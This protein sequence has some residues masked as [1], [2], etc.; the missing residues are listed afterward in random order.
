MAGRI[1]IADGVAT[2]RIILKVKLATACYEVIQAD[3]AG[4]ALALARSK[5]P[6]LILLDRALPGDG[7]VACR[8]L[9]ADPMTAAI[10]LVFLSAAQDRAVR[11]AALRS[12]ADEVVAKPMHEKT[13][14]AL[15]R[16]LIRSRATRDEL[17]RRSATAG[18]LG[19]ADA[20][21]PFTQ[22]P[23]I[24]VIA[25]R[26]ETA[27]AWRAG[28]GPFLGSR[29]EVMDRARALE[30]APGSCGAD[31]YVVG[32]GITGPGGGVGLVSE[33]RSHPATR[34]A[35]IVVHNPDGNPEHT[36]MA[37]DLG[38]S[39]VIAGPFDGEELAA[40][41]DRLLP[42]KLETDF[43]RDNLEHR[44]SLAMKDP[45]TGAYNRRYAQACLARI[46]E[47]SQAGDQPF[48]VMVLDLDR[49]KAVN[50]IHGHAA[51][52][53]VLIET[54]RRLAGSL[55]EIDLLARIGGEEFLVA[56]PGTGPRQARRVA[57]R[58]RRVIGDKPV[59]LAGGRE[60]KV[61]M[62]IGVAVAQGRVEDTGTGI[63]Q[64]IESADRALY[65]SKAEGR[66]LVTFTRPAA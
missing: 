18:D 29:I 46:A 54:A 27:M 33:L 26:R 45:L 35:V 24:V 22:P 19:F 34:D 51:G 43:L 47:A 37:L 17:A 61:T 3:D 12:G 41:I 11:L 63:E 25:P 8:A 32:A 40:R 59:E 62:S 42:R 4:G 31:V 23:R 48:A 28:L 39:T 64:L 9:K 21:R 6:D 65:A 1:L 20:P 57:E 50:D 52:D 58:L 53:Q 7:V 15:V 56:M 60:V 44:L 30:A 49:F 2:N 66:N 36:A 55:R 16:N 5:Q 38:A 13:L 14:L 10:P